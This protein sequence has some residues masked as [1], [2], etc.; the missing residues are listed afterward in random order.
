MQKGELRRP[1][2]A[3]DRGCVLAR[4]VDVTGLVGRFSVAL[5]DRCRADFD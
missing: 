1:L 4:L 2:L 5:T 3:C